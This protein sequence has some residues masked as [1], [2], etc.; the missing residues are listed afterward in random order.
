[1]LRSTQSEASALL[2]LSQ[3]LLVAIGFGCTKQNSACCLIQV[4]LVQV[5]KRSRAM[6]ESRFHRVACTSHDKPH[7]SWIYLKPAVFAFFT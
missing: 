2:G 5:L 1:M 3:G 4:L 7:E 6:E